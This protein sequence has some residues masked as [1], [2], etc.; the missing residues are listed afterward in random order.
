ML[1]KRPVSTLFASPGSFDLIALRVAR[2][3]AVSFK[4]E[5]VTRAES[6]LW[7]ASSEADATLAPC[8]DPK[9][10]AAAAASAQ[11]ACVISGFFMAA[12]KY[13]LSADGQAIARRFL[14]RK[15]VCERSAT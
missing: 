7:G 15:R 8:R 13:T 10:K 5:A 12:A 9:T 3:S 11:Q 2:A 4:P 1:P 6:G 14:R